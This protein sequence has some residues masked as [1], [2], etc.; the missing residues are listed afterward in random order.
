MRVA[1]EIERQLPER[2]ERGV[3][4]APA[5]QCCC[6][7]CCCCLHSLGGAIG[8]LSA[9]SKP[10]DSKLPVSAIDRRPLEPRHTASGLYWA[11]VAI[12]SG[13]VSAYL[14]A[15]ER[16]EIHPSKVWFMVVL[17]L[18]AVQLVASIIAALVLAGSR[19]VG[20]EQRL[21]HLMR[22]TVRAFLGALIGGLLMLP[23]LSK[24]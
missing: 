9:R 2:G 4:A 1:I 12:V 21:N 3:T 13:L 14:V 7:C 17:L 24:C 18:P 8:A 20:K 5:G 11:I 19:R 22:I 6:C 10:V 23:M 16:E 15:F